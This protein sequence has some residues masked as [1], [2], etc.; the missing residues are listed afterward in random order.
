MP[1]AQPKC[2]ERILVCGNQVFDFYETIVEGDPNFGTAL[3]NRVYRTCGNLMR[4]NV[5]FDE[6]GIEVAYVECLDIDPNRKR[7][8]YISKRWKRSSYGGKNVYKFYRHTRYFMF[9]H[10]T[11]CNQRYHWRRFSKADI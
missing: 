4:I 1:E 10:C 7:G 9:V 11:A 6:K 3:T 5:T 2:E 8:A